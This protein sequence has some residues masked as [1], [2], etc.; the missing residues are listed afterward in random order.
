MIR[1]DLRRLLADKAP[2]LHAA[3]TGLAH[4]MLDEG[5]RVQSVREA[6]DPM[7]VQSAEVVGDRTHFPVRTLVRAMEQLDAEFLLRRALQKESIEVRKSRKRTIAAQGQN[8]AD[9]LGALRGKILPPL[10]AS[11]APSLKARAFEQIR[12]GFEFRFIGFLKDVREGP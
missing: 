1:Q 3:D 4:L 7:H 12:K 6:S 11:G 2:A 8:A 10:H 5:T 9:I